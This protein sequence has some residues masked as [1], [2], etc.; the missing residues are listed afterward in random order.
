MKGYP[1]D[2][3]DLNETQFEGF[4]NNTRRRLEEGMTNYQDMQDAKYAN[5]YTTS[6]GADQN[7]QKYIKSL[8]HIG[9][10]ANK[11][12]DGYE[13]FINT[14]STLKQSSLTNQR[15]KQQL[16]TRPFQGWPYMGA[17]STHIVNPD[18]YSQLAGG[19]DTRTKKAGDALAGVSIDRFIPMV[20]CLARNIQDPVH[21]VP[22]YWVRGGESSRSWLQNMDYFKLCGI[23]R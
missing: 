23:R 20:P 9:M 6:Y 15:N 18:L 8:D 11:N 5:Y 14:E 12:R 2:G 17:G 22:E 1:I 13:S 7:R 4:N 21:I 3:N 16:T 19:T 10:S